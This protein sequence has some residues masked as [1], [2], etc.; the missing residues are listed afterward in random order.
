MAHTPQ[1]TL[2]GRLDYTPDCNAS[3]LL[4]GHTEC[5][6]VAFNMDTYFISGDTFYA[7]VV[8]GITEVL[9]E[10]GYTLHFVCL[11]ETVP[12]AP[13]RSTRPLSRRDIDGLL[14]LNWLDPALLERMRAVGVPLVVVDASGAVS[15][16]PAVDNDHRGG[17]AMGVRY[18]RELGHRHITLLNL[19]LDQP[20]AR[21]VLAGYL[22]AFEEHGVEIAPWLLRSCLFGIAHG[23]QVM[24]ELLSRSR[25][26]TAVF[27]DGDEIAVGDMQ[28]IQE[29]GLHIP[30]AIS[31]VGM[32]DIS[33][34]AE[35]RPALTTVRIDMA[36]LGRQA[37]R[38]L[39][40][41]IAGRAHGQP[42]TVLPTHLVMRN[43]TAPPLLAG[44]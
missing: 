23:R 18:L 12:P 30:N 11:D 2:D 1:I 10:S 31:V 9:E 38:A 22:Q 28:A 24:A 6:G 33:I 44:T 5:I 37:T 17:A 15:D 8:R 35:V 32:G 4:R 42:R 29:A 13:H 39:L 14:V 41:L 43:S 25:S 21:E 34:A 16:L 20:F 7:L 3:R 36:A 40:A 27:A 26:P 19:S